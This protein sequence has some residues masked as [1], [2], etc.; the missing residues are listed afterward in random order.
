MIA[1]TVSGQVRGSPTSHGYAWRGISFAQPPTAALRFRPPQPPRPWT[2]VRPALQDGPPCVQ[3]CA[4]NQGSEDC[5]YLS[6]YAPAADTA[7]R[8]VLVWIHG[9]AFFMGSRSEVSGAVLA[10]RGDVVVV[11]VNYRPGPFGF[12]HLSDLGLAEYADSGNSP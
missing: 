6:V 2:G 12:S 9:G 4:P 1:D 5:L 7:H 10:G 11:T 8:P 3:I